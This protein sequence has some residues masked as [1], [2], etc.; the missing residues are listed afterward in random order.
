MN[1]ICIGCPLGCELEIGFNG[2]IIDYVKGY[3]CNIGKEYAKKECTN[4]TRILTAGIKIK[5]G[6]KK[7]ISVKTDSDIPK[8]Y[9]F[10]CLDELKDLE[11]EAPVKIGEIIL[12]NIADIGVNIIAT[13]NCDKLTVVVE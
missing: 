11:I 6:N 10:K 2:K 13:S 4:P 3:N 5:G 1:L 12:R 9:I 7:V 8:D